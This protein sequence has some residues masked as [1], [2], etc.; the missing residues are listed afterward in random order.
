MELIGIYWKPCNNLGHSFSFKIKQID[1]NNCWA[2]KET[3]LTFIAR[4][5]VGTAPEG[6]KLNSN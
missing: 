6:S 5:T 2:I 3:E 1:V 4:F